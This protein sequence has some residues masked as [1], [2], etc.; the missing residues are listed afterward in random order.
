M[1]SN[2]KRKPEPSSNP[3]T[4]PEIVG[5]IRLERGKKAYEF[6]RAQGTF[7]GTAPMK[8]PPPFEQL[9]EP[10]QSAWVRAVDEAFGARLEEAAPVSIT[11]HSPP[12]QE[13]A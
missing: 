3:L 1:R 10:L 11:S 6:M 7:Y 8:A 9:P 5:R 12:R 13:I 4:G 2:G